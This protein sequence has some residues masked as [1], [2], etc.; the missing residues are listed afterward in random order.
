MA[1]QIVDDIKNRIQ[2]Q[3]ATGSPVVLDEAVIGVTNIAELFGLD[4]GQ[5][6]GSKGMS[7]M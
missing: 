5:N 6:R 3:L 7:P 2:T 1:S 4:F